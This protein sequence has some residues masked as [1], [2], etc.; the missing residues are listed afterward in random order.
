MNLYNQLEI[1]HK[2]F[3]EHVYEDIAF[4]LKDK[5]GKSYNDIL[6]H[7]KMKYTFYNFEEDK[8]NL[9]KNVQ[10]I[11][12]NK[13]V[14]SATSYYNYDKNYNKNDLR[15]IIK[16]GFYQFMNNESIFTFD[17]A[18]AIDKKLYNID[19]KFWYNAYQDVN[20]IVLESGL[21]T[22]NIIQ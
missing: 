9:I 21:F 4:Y 20:F 17:V 12:V 2:E 5:H 3:F 6:E 1:A 15:N 16:K 10:Q 8:F 19:S 13:I 7:L 11:L 22:C 14:N 18:R